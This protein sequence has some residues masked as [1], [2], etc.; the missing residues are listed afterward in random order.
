MSVLSPRQQQEIGRATECELR[1]DALSRQLYAT[2][3]SIYQVEPAGVALPRSVAEVAS[4]IKAIASAGQAVIPRGAGTGLAGGAIGAGIVM[5]FARYNRRITHFDRARRSVRVEPGVVLDQLNAYLAP[6]GLWFGPDVATSSRATLGGMIANNSSGAHAPVYGTTVDHVRA[7]EIVLADGTVA[8]IGAGHAG[9]GSCQAAIDRIVDQHL[10]AIATRLPP[11][12]IKRWPGYGLDDYVRDGYNLTRLISGSEGTLAVITAAELDL[13]PLPA[14]RGLGIVFFDSVAAAMAATVELLDLEAAAIEH[15]DRLLF[16]Q[17][18]GQRAFKAARALL[19]LDEAPCEAILLVEFFDHVA[20]KLHILAQ[21]KIGLRQLITT[22]PREQELIWSIRKAGLSLVTGCPGPAK[23]TPGIEDVCVRPDQLP[24]Y[25]AGLRALLDPLGIEA[26]YY[27]HAAAGE[28]HVRPKLDLHTAAD[29]AKYRQIADG[30]SQLCRRFHGSIAAEHGVGMARTEFLADHLGPELVEA[31]RQIKRQFD[32]ANVLNP[33]KIVAN[34]TYRIETNLRLG[35]GYAFA[36]PQVPVI[37]FVD[38]DHSLVA[39]LEQ[40]NGC[41]GCRKDAPSMCPTYIA[42]G[43]EIM[44]TR[45]RANTI[46]AVLDGRFGHDAD[47]ILG[48]ELDV[49]LSNC[50]SCKACKTECPSNVDLALIKAELL[51]ARHQRGGLALVDRVIA[52]A[53]RLGRLASGPLAPVANAALRSRP[54]RW[55]LHRVF[56]LTPRRPL[57]PFARQRFDR[58]FAKHKTRRRPGRERVILWDDTWVRYH[59]PNIGRAAVQVLEAAGLEVV[60]PEGRECCGRPACSRGVLA[61]AKRLGQHNVDWFQ[62]HD[63]S[64]PIIFLEPSCYSMFVDEY[65]QFGIPGADQLAQRCILFEP[66]LLNLL[67]RCP[68][69]LPWN[70]AARHIAMHDHCHSKALTDVQALPQLAARIPGT[71]FEVLEVAC[72]GMAGAFGMLESKYELSLAIARPLVAQVAALPP[73]TQVVASG[74]SCRHQIAHLTDA[75]PLHMAELVAGALRDAHG[76]GA[77]R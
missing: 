27:G 60:L 58:W 65:R 40:C 73:G 14:D 12:L 33:G 36:L 77:G 53:D 63:G 34:G 45:G 30:V 67:E 24:E 72:C 15:I 17:T 47:S 66:F 49:A 41:G 75:R 26:S 44:S 11:T 71:S 57:P 6:H 52:G 43:E 46:R 23:P 20:D 70:H 13:V 31:T 42:T 22:D 74:T 64:E 48:S 21:R 16:D 32:P 18:R 56:G 61:E 62:R 38:K 39:N 59:E 1:F 3:A 37:G 8:W 2:D 19:R 35:A 4:A 29:I 9:L 68:T 54:M 50:L 55:I 69:A 10:A 51:H 7:L 25:V 28:L 76:Y 5:D